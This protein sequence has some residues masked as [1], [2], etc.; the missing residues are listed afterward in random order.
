[1]LLNAAAIIGDDTLVRML[2][3]HRAEID[4]LEH[5]DGASRPRSQSAIADALLSGHSGN[6]RVLSGHGTNIQ[7]RRIETVRLA[8]YAVATGHLTMPRL[9]LEN[10]ADMSISYI[11][12]YTLRSATC[13]TDLSTDIVRF[14]LDHGHERSAAARTRS[15]IYPGC[16]TL[17]CLPHNT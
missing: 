10:E 1:M 17:G 6:V 5:R 3:G 14:L 16:N 2:L 7:G 9:L 12:V 4:G 8:M 13:S 15:G 11:P